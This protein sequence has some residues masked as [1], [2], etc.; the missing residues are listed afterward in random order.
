MFPSAVPRREILRLGGISLLGL[1]SSSEVWAE[2]RGTGW[3]SSRQCVFIMLQGAPSHIDLWDPKPSAP[4][5]VRGPFQTIETSVPEIKFGELLQRTSKLAH[6]LTL[7][8]SM[9]HRFTNHI[10]GTYV[11]L[12]G[13]NTQIDADRE[14]HVDDFPGPGA[15]LNYMEGQAGRVPASISLPNWLSIPGPS[16]RMPGQYAGFLGSNHD[17]FLIQG[18]PQNKD[19]KPLQLALP[20]GTTQERFQSRRDLLNVLD[21]GARFTETQATKT[22]DH[23]YETAY[24]LLT[25]PRLRNALDLQQEPDVVRQRYGMSKIGQSLLLAR[26]LIEAGVKFVAYNEFNQGWD[27]HGDIKNS[28]NGRVPQ[29]EQGYSALLEDLHVRGLLPNTLVVNTGEFGRTPVINASAGRDHWPNVYT[30]VLVGG[31]I[32]GGQIYGCS[33]SRGAEVSQ[34]PVAPADILATMWS[35]MGVDPHAELRDRLNRPFPIS[36]GRIMAEL[37]G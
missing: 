11:T 35:C 26:R 1:G 9:T 8:R 16:N 19:F 14:A 22:R 28:L 4:D 25:D 7:V 24:G 6:H 2:A 32:R 36:A 27:H 30:T 29:M 23:L 10:A 20:D 37:M 31:G 18:E 13:S 15:I 21:Q 12:T 33:D 5:Q 34:K 17:P 3:K